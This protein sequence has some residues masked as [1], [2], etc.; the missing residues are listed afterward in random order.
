MTWFFMYR[1]MLS[2]P[3]PAITMGLYT[4]L[5]SA[6]LPLNFMMNCGTHLPVC[7]KVTV[8]LRWMIRLDC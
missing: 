8:S 4:P 1:V 2:V 7:L 3:V 5:T 6:G